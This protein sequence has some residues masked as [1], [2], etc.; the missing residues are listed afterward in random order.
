[1]PS[2]SLC[3]EDTPWFASIQEPQAVLLAYPGQGQGRPGLYPARGGGIAGL[4]TEAGWQQQPCGTALPGQADAPWK[5]VCKQVCGA[6]PPGV[7]GAASLKGSHGTPEV[8]GTLDGITALTKER[9]QVL[10]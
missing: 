10:Q 2:F 5:Q 3:R 6:V 4:G 8:W 9:R 7:G 1:M